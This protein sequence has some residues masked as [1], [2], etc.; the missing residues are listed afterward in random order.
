MIRA[1]LLSLTL[2]VLC[3]AQVVHRGDLQK[4]HVPRSAEEYAK[5]LDDPQRDAWQKPH[6]VIQALELKPGST[7]ADLG[8]GSGYFTLRFAHMLGPRGKVLAVDI[9]PKLLE[10]VAQRAKE[11]KA[12]NVETVLA[13][14]NDPKLAAG[15]VDVIFICDVIHHIDQRPAYYKLLARA[16][17]PDGRLVIVD[18][19]KRELPVGP[20]PAMKIAREDLIQE[21]ETAG[22]HLAREHTFLPYQYFLVFQAGAIQSADLVL[23]NG[24]IH[25]VNDRQPHVE[26]VAAR[27]GKIVFA[28]STT[29]AKKYIGPTTNALDLKGLTVVPGLADSHY[30]LSGVGAREIRLNLE[31]ITSL[32]GFLAAVKARVD[33]AKP[34]EW[35]TGGGWNEGTWKPQVFPTR[36][37]L[38]K[39]APANPVWLTRTDGHGSVANSAA[40]RIAGITKAT[41]DPFGGEIMRDRATGESSGMFLDNAQRLVS[42]YVPPD[43]PGQLRRELLLGVE[44]SLKLGWTQVSIP[45][46]SYP[47]V[48][49]IRKLY[50]EG[51]IKLRIYDAVRGPSDDT[52]RILAEGPTIGAYNG[53]FT[54][55][56][57][58]VS[59]DGAIGSKGAALLAPY[60]DHDT[61]GFL[62]WKEEDLL[63][64][65]QE[66]LR[67]GIQVQT[68]A[69]GDRANREILN[70]YAKAFD[71]VPNSQRKVVE[72][73]WRVEHAQHVS[74]QD[75]PR[76]A[77]LKVIPSM[78]PSHAISDLLFLKS[79]LGL[80]RMGDA[81]AWRKFIESGSMIA[82][83]SD[84]PVERG[85][86]MIEFYAAV[87]RKTLK[88]ESGEGWHPELA[89]SREQ[90][91]K[92]FTL[93]AACS[94]FEENLRGSIEPGK[95]AD[96]T[97]LS[98]DIL[99]VPE[100][101]I[102]KTTC[103]L[104]VINGEVVYPAP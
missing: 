20:P 77:K 74:A 4:H 2:S 14:P 36:W 9:D 41:K 70:Y 13:A 75:I 18:F 59:F 21:V 89:V 95:W 103:Q 67:K 76:F 92:M 52:K 61:A 99:K 24:N 11:Q 16:L 81:Y 1:F 104:T 25:T 101:E 72:P 42:K 50:E 82:G 49:E 26:A 12:A 60:A 27:R 97:V 84:A 44:R 48:E 100:P 32:A 64:M 94:T 34:G 71:Y 37:D 78:Q 7:V 33:L 3:P 51:K 90:A 63:P 80:Q 73:R 43:P 65:F 68:H 55:R 57:I 85:E 66:A 39:V 30:H 47:E 15:S 45:G 6:E 29:D 83:G 96:F 22:F 40:I 10:K 69:I 91:L 23:Y 56:G 58:K 5:V 38:D 28:G 79:R 35:I 31:G 86:P 87:A 54:L 62:K 53:R 46:N 19:H 17:Q 8:A 88:G 102:L 98:Q 93:W